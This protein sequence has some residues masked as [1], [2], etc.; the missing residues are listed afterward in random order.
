MYT[1]DSA[2]I[3]YR[4]VTFLLGLGLIGYILLSAIKKQPHDKIDAIIQKSRSY[5][6]FFFENNKDSW[7]GQLLSS[8][9]KLLEEENVFYK[10]LVSAKLINPL[11]LYYALRISKSIESHH[12]ACLYIGSG[13]DILHPMLYAFLNVDHSTPHKEVT[14]YMLDEQSIS[15]NKLQ[16]IN[17]SNNP[18][19]QK[20]H[21]NSA[22]IDR[23]YNQGIM[24]SYANND[25]SLMIDPVHL[26]HYFLVSLSKDNQASYQVENDNTLHLNWHNMRFKFC[27]SSINLLDI[28]NLSR[29]IK[30]ENIST[31]NMVLLSKAFGSFFPTNYL[32]MLKASFDANNIPFFSR[33]ISHAAFLEPDSNYFLNP[34]CFTRKAQLE[35]QFIPDWEI[36]KAAVP[37]LEELNAEISSLSLTYQPKRE[38]TPYHLPILCDPKKL[39]HLLE[40]RIEQYKKELQTKALYS[41]DTVEK[42]KYPIHLDEETERGAIVGI[43]YASNQPQGSFARYRYS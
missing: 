33:V 8:I 29:F 23:L 32:A 9:G 30:S 43:P 25:P 21:Q 1:V 36:Q 31:H 35:R 19:F 42:P 41:D 40:R 24:I 39:M 28:G 11:L 10:Q 6:S 3:D 12:E 15:L 22:V 37:I 4:F 7:Y 20:S 34:S 16:S 26:L 27:F 18:L 17:H 14:I 38:I 5:H 2:E 13:V